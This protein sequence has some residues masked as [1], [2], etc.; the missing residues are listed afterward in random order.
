MT[1]KKETKKTVKA[2]GYQPRLKAYYK[3]NCRK[4]KISFQ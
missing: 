2:E 4:A 1:E 3:E